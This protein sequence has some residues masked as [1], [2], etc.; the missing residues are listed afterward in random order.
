M[1]KLLLAFA[2]CAAMCGASAEP[3]GSLKAEGEGLTF[4]EQG[5][6]EIY[7]WE[8]ADSTGTFTVPEGGATVDLL[9]VGGGGA[10]GFCR[11]GG[12]GGGGVIYKQSYA[13]DA[14]SYTVTVGAGG[15]PDRW[16]KD[17]R[18]NP[19]SQNCY[20][21]VKSSETTC[22][23]NSVL[24]LSGEAVQ[25]AIGG[26]GGGSFVN[27]KTGDSEGWG[28]GSGGGS[29]GKSATCPS[30]TDGQGFAGGGGGGAVNNDNVSGGGGGAGA[31]GVTPNSTNASGNGGDGI[32]CSITGSPVYYGGGGGGGAYEDR[33]PGQGGQGGGGNGGY[34]KSANEGMTAGV[35]G[36]G[37]GGG[38]ASGSGNK[39][40]YCIGAPGGSGVVI[41]RYQKAGAMALNV[42]VDAGNARELDVTASVTASDGAETD[43]FDIY[44]ACSDSDENF[45]YAKVGEDV[46]LNAE[47]SKAFV[48]LDSD[49]L[50]YVAA[51]AYNRT[52]GKW[53]DP[54]VSQWRTS[55]AESPVQIMGPGI[56]KTETGYEVFVRI[57]HFQGNVSDCTLTY[58]GE[59]KAV[60]G[61]GTYAWQVE[62]TAS[63]FSATVD[64]AYQAGGISY[65]KTVT[66]KT[67]GGASVHIADFATLNESFF[68][69]GDRILLPE[70]SYSV[71][72]DAIATVSDNVVQCKK[73][74]FTLLYDGVSDYRVCVVP[75]PP[76]GGDVFYY[77]SN[78]G[79]G[80]PWTSATWTKV[81]QNTERTYP[82]DENDVAVIEGGCT[83]AKMLI[84]DDISLHGYVVGV[85]RTISSG[86]GWVQLETANGKALTFCG[87]EVAPA[88]FNLSSMSRQTCRIRLGKQDGTG[89]AVLNV[90]VSGRLNFDWC[91]DS[92]SAVQPRRG[93][94]QIQWCS[95]IV[96][97]PEGSTLAFVN[98]SKV[99]TDSIVKGGTTVG[100]IAGAGTVIFG[101]SGGIP[102][103]FLKFAG[104]EFAGDVAVRAGEWK[105]MVEFPDSDLTVFDAP[106]AGRKTIGIGYDL[107]KS[108]PG[109][110]QIDAKSVTLDGGCLKIYRNYAENSNLTPWT[111]GAT[112]EEE[113]AARLTVTNEIKKLIVKGDSAFLC[114]CSY[115][116]TRVRQH[117][118]LDEIEH[119][120][121]GTICLYDFNFRDKDFRKDPLHY[122]RVRGDGLAAHAVGRDRQEGDSQFVYKIIPWIACTANDNGWQIY[123][124][125]GSEMTFPALTNGV[126]GLAL[127]SKGRTNRKPSQVVSEWENVFFSDKGVGISTNT[128]INSFVY[129]TA[130]TAPFPGNLVLG[131]GKTLT[132]K[133]GGLIMARTG[134]WLGCTQTAKFAENGSI[135]FGGE[136]AYVIGDYGK[137]EGSGGA[138]EYN[139]IWASMIAP[140]GLT[141]GGCGELVFATD[142]RGID[143]DIVIGGGKL[144]LGHPANYTK[145]G[146][147]YQN[148]SDTI[149]VRGCATD[150]E[151]FTLR[152][153]AVLAIP[154]KGYDVDGSGTIDEGETAI[155]KNAVIT[156]IDNAAGSSKVEIAAGADQ[157]CKKLYI[158]GRN[159]GKA[160]KRGTY[161][162][163][164]SGADYIDDVHFAGTGVLTVR[165]DD[166]AG[167]YLIIR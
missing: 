1:K 166:A 13:L 66:Q 165:K 134:R 16:T 124:T 116:T 123:N 50:Y 91:G 54:L 149:P 144:W 72:G 98:D 73:S 82:D 92:A 78:N 6:F 163:T 141:K 155:S 103:S 129:N 49:S 146:W 11:G 77:F 67:S 147:L 18:P 60:T 42:Q 3:V 126:H 39:W 36:L 26:G 75:H 79:N 45:D 23:G 64:L 44:L 68:F 133:S 115:G 15:V 31:A 137:P 148:Q 108:N 2:A 104:D 139:V 65:G 30:G 122:D 52:T 159:K 12:G 118:I 70:G 94:G 25:T 38:G 153:G 27:G 33:T 143:G 89:D 83:W 32:E 56:T 125:W 22:G 43:T 150:V 84:N 99:V 114:E 62:S 14:G 69:E 93:E 80:D 96:T 97:V 160:L 46:A 20:E 131:A 71:L 24:T 111:E 5:A 8:G 132:I 107:C 105:G 117:L 34:K 167:M 156:L 17:T 128:T 138:N 74:G 112:T 162:A 58:K 41:V 9:L 121:T 157:T 63:D 154:S 142:Q 135:A 100:H 51:K 140:N 102:L 161:G 37:G 145:L 48:G 120:K 81:T 101:Q 76:A 57:D 61:V 10:G 35:D 47:V 7:Q 151:E 87:S 164:G 59:A 90:S 4:K 21:Q 88:I 152:P 158:S 127:M 109:R 136:R 28:G 110:S 40:E 86:D 106:N 95:A 19:N 55:A 130:E 29:A 53:S 119:D 113:K 85:A